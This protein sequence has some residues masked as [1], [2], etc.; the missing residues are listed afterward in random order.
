MFYFVSDDVNALSK[1][2]IQYQMNKSTHQNV[3]VRAC[4]RTYVRA[5]ARARVCVWV[6]VSGERGVDI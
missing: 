2:G 1:L 3:C 6:C 5:R 4:V